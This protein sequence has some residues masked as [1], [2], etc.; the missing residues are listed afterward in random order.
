MYEQLKIAREEYQ[1]KLKTGLVQRLTPHERALENP[2]SLRYA[3]NAKC[4]EC[5]GG[6][7]WI[8]RTQFCNIINCP[9]WHVR[10]FANR[11]T[12]EECLHWKEK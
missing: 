9:L 1:R 10:K 5:N 2:T 8:N 11:A 7:N 6:E 4:W 3:I 12:K